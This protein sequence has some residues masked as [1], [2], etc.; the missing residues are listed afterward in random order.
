MLWKYGEDLKHIE[1]SK[2]NFP[3]TMYT[4]HFPLGTICNFK[5]LYSFFLLSKDFTM[6]TKKNQETIL[7]HCLNTCWPTLKD[8]FQHKCT[9]KRPACIHLKSI[10]LRLSIYQE[11]KINLILVSSILAGELTKFSFTKKRSKLHS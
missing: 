7:I 9:H 2:E 8:T 1:W 6:V 11:N 10:M 4:S 3:Q 5:D